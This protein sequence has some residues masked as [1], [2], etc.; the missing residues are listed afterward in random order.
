MKNLLFC[1]SRLAVAGLLLA[2]TSALRAAADRVASPSG[3]LGIT[4]TLDSNG[5]PLFSV[6]YLGRPLVLPSR[7]GLPANL[8]ANLAAS[9]TRT[10]NHD[11]VWENPRGERRRVPDRYNALSVDL[12]S[13]EGER[14]SLTFR[15]YD[16]GAAFI[17]VAPEGGAQNAAT[18]TDRTEFHFPPNTRTSPASAATGDAP[19]ILA[20]VHA[21]EIRN[22]LTITLA[23]GRFASL[24]TLREAPWKIILVGR[25]PAQ[26]LER[27]YLALNFTAPSALADTSWIRPGRV[28]RDFAPTLAGAKAAADYGVTAGFRYICAGRAWTE[29]GFDV[30]ALVGYARER[31]LGVILRVADQP[32]PG[33]LETTLRQFA[34]WGV[35]GAEIALPPG[36][37]HTATLWLAPAAALAAQLHLILAVP[38]TLATAERIR[39]WPHVF[40]V[41]TERASRPTDAATENC[42][43]PFSRG[44]LGFAPFSEL[45]TDGV[46]P[47]HR[48]ALGVIS[49]DPLASV[50]WAERPEA[51]SR[52]HDQ[53]FLRRV[54]TVWDDT[55]AL[56]GASGRY[57][58]LARR[59]RDD[60]FVGAING[61]DARALGLSLAFLDPGRAYIA[62]LYTDS[63]PGAS[64]QKTV[65]AY[66]KVVST[67]RIDLALATGGGTAIWLTPDSKRR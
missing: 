1:S 58:A 4:F 59:S 24:A 39:A 52:A 11:A 57:L 3:A 2:S 50:S 13:R 44:P 42:T 48:L 7:L 29:P 21:S 38:R 10:E 34:R 35:R 43:L 19:L 12:R 8:A 14:G 49:S 66:R 54:P 20:S 61:S 53:E 64:P 40:A 45:R 17:F 41:A 5:S 37:A 22:P 18:D 55:K 33:E 31:D 36:A 9:A 60:W 65:Y 51:D 28:L 27:N 47:A 62:H 32:Q 6:D 46:S 23:D 30:P 56:A 16:E 25:D 15:A 26:L 67:E 63:P